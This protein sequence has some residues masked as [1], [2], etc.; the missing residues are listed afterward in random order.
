M[1]QPKEL[2]QVISDGEIVADLFRLART[3]QYS[4]VAPLL[5]EAES[6]YPK[7]PKNE[8]RRA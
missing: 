5:K 3:G 2:A 4:K 8:S 1:N 7:E 6:M